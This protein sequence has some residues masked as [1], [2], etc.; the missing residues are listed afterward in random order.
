MAL[1][2]RNRTMLPSL[3]SDLLDT[4]TLLPNVFDLDEDLLNFSGRSLMIPSANIIES[5]KD[6]RIELAA[7]GLERKDFKVEV[8]NGIL[9][10][11]GEKEEEEKEEKGNYRRRE[12]SYNSFNRSF[13]LP[14]NSLPDKIEAKYDNGILH[15]ML[16]KREATI[17]KTVKEIKV[18]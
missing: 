6:F 2:V 12:Y 10:I 9:T 8:D 18:S 4:E 11:T 15:V 3:V 1:L 16:P 17:S 14:E 5:E 7:P 13:A